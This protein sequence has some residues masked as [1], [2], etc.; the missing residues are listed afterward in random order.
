MIISHEHR[1]I[2]VKTRKTAGTSIEV[3]L[4]RHAGADAIVTPVLPPVAGHEARHHDRPFNPLPEIV[5]RRRV[6]PA[7]SDLRRRRT[8]FNHI[9]A[10]RI[11]ERIG[12]RTWDSYFKF[13]F[14][15][16][17]WDKV[18]SWFYWQ[19]R[20][21][22]RL[23]FRDFVL[24]AP[25]P[26]DFDRYSIRGELAMDY[27]G[28]FEHLSDD[29]ATVFARVGIDAPVELTREKGGVRPT[30]ER[31]E[32]RYT[33]E[34]D[35]RVATVFARELAHFDYEDRSRRAGAAEP[36]SGP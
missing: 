12:V 7:L 8:F 1:F 27:V 20:A 13:T 4:A 10:A 31:P 15:R 30:G 16:D 9:D 6:K 35:A 2:F 19:M 18:V 23:D 24:T 22:D 28:R 14:E 33:P 21:T 25:L 36:P 3:L 32:V 26:T 17:P 34:L 29:L 5:R 11:R